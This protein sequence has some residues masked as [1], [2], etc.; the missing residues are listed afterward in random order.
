M[1]QDTTQ[2][3]SEARTTRSSSAGRTRMS[4]AERAELTRRALLEAAEH[5]FLTDGYHATSLEAIAADAGYSTGAIFAAFQ[6]KAGLFL[7]LADEVFARRLQQVQTLFEA[8]PAPEARLAA[9]ASQPI[10]ARNENWLLLAIEFWTHSA[11]NDDV[12]AA[13]RA[14][15]GRLHKGVAELAG[16][17]AG[18]LGA[19]HWATVVLALSNGLTLARRIDPDSVPADLM[20]STLALLQRPNQPSAS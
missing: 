13:F 9:L 20:A 8:F 16:Q 18:P 4:R 10:D 19:H 17:D 2:A 5:R 11:R 15:Y 6:S 12:M 3:A 7:A 1:R 14:S